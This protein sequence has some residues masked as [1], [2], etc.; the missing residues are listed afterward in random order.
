MD[1]RSSAGSASLQRS[2]SMLILLTLVCCQERPAGPPPHLRA[3]PG[4]VAACGA[5]TISGDTLRAA[6]SAKRLRAADV[7]PSLIADACLAEGAS[8]RDIPPAAERESL[9]RAVL[10]RM[11]LESVAR[12]SEVNTPVSAP[13]LVLFREAHWTEVDRP[14]AARVMH[15]VVMP[16]ER[17]AGDPERLRGLA[18]RI[19]DA[20][21]DAP[22]PATFKSLALAAAAGEPSVKIESLE[23]VVA[24]GRV[25]SVAPARYDPSFSKAALAL[26]RP[27]E[28]SPVIESPFG[29]HV[30]FLLEILP[31]QRLDDDRLRELIAPEVRATRARVVVEG[32]LARHRAAASIDI[33]RDLG[34]LTSRIPLGRGP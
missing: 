10:A 34:D 33:A 19:R 26:S 4:A 20:V 31:A 8:R 16:P 1:A 25:V 22:D 12:S 32:V 6:A 13:E 11:L 5:Q 3:T 21:R 27:G 2:W 24:D 9:R 17:G 23:P 14:A 30:L 28:T 29:F 18:A 7:L 15:A